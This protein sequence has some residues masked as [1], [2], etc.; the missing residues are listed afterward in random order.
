MT[1]AVANTGNNTV[2]YM[3]A[4][5]NEIAHAL[6]NKAVTTESNT[7][8]GNAAITGTF[9]ANKLVANTLDISGGGTILV[10]NL[11][12]NAISIN[13][14]AFSNVTTNNFSA[15]TGTITDLTSNNITVANLIANAFTVTSLALTSL[16]GNA[17]TFNYLTANTLGTFANLV[18]NNTRTSTLS[19]GNSTVNTV[20]TA[21]NS[22]AVSNGHYYL[23]A[24]GGWNYIEPVVVPGSNTQLY[25]NDS[26]AANAISN[27]TFSKATGT[28]TVINAI[29][30]PIMASNAMMMQSGQILLAG[31]SQQAVDTVPVTTFRGAEYSYTMKDQNANNFSMGKVLVLHSGASGSAQA[32]EYATILSNSAMGS[33]DASVNATHLSLLYTPISSSVTVTFSKTS[34]VT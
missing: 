31:T 33:W 24:N 27:L 11:T 1:V 18:A 17:A 7:A 4:R 29:A 30:V 26:G 25:F 3:I 21:A 16:T 23:N 5:L 12:A 6:S 22:A 2:A 15:T 34:L 20:I 28:L 32:V 13:S 9:T 10:A 8:S 14:A 19:V